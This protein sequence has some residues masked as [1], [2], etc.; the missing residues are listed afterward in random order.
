MFLLRAAVLFVPMRMNKSGTQTINQTTA[1]I[2]G[3]TV[4]PAY[5][6][7]DIVTN[8]NKMTMKTAGD[9]KTVTAAVV[10]SGATN[11]YGLSAA[12][13]RNN[14]Q[15]GTTQSLTTTSGTLSFNIPNVTVGATDVFELRG[16]NSFFGATV[17]PTGTF[18]Q[19][20]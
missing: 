14:V 12:L 5:P 19:V 2:A 1:V 9:G 13:Y 4:D 3:W 16:T 7:T 10:F 18:L 20:I 15:L 17:Q 11:G 8:A 6:D